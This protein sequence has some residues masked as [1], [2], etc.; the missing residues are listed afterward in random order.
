M[1][2]P[3]LQSRARDYISLTHEIGAIK[4]FNEVKDLGYCQLHK[5]KVIY[6]GVTHTLDSHAEALAFI[7][8]KFW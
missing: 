8:R 6:K 7:L 1:S 2:I 5:N 4:F 3:Y